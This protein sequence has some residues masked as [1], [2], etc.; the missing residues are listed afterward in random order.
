M[1]PKRYSIDTL[2]KA[3]QNPQKL[4]R[5]IKRI[6]DSAVHMPRRLLFSSNHEYMSDIM[7]EDWDNLIILDA[8]RYD[9]INDTIGDH[10]VDY[11]NLDSSTSSEF[12]DKYFKGNEYR[13][14]IY[15]TSNPYGAR[16]NDVFY[17][18]IT[19]YDGEY[20][21]IEDTHGESWKP[22]IVFD[23]ALGVIKE[24]PNKKM[25]VHFMQP[26][27][28][29]FGEAADQL[30]EKI[31]TRGYEF[32]AWDDGIEREEMDNNQYILSNL[33]D[34]A[35]KGVI[36]ADELIEVYIENLEIVL[37]YAYRLSDKMEGKTV[38]TADHGEMLGEN[39][40]LLVSDMRGLEQ[41][42][43]HGRNIYT[44]ELRQ[45]PWIV[46]D[47]DIRKEVTKADKIENS[48][49]IDSNIEDQLR[50]LGYHD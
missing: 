41:N 12:I 7:A 19:P 11:K 30:R 14:T 39:K 1:I 23:T 3:L 47:S 21:I 17:K 44:E 42:F 2:I 36:T 22:D 37:E 31:R 20:D 43:G 50:A 27:A 45:V 28:P 8:C 34:A 9:I 18:K 40:H 38:L 49:E 24:N 16:V 10:D 32:W 35:K 26:H 5:E 13:D 25:I 46:L 29:Y 6:L 15:V 33:L 48:E 4:R